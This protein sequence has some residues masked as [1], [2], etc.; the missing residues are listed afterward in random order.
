MDDAFDRSLEALFV[1]LPQNGDQLRENQSSIVHFRF[2]RI[3]GI[4]E[5]VGISLR[6]R[7]KRFN[8]VRTPPR[9]EMCRLL[10]HGILDDPVSQGCSPLMAEDSLL[11]LFLVA[12]SNKRCCNRVPPLHFIL[13]LVLDALGEFNHLEGI[14]LV[15]VHSSASRCKHHCPGDVGENMS[16]RSDF[17]HHVL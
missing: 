2:P 9:V 7:V 4:T 15:Q 14:R 6:Q 17:L 10:I 1:V 3:E 12:Y 11:S 5:E 13:R 16:P 8:N